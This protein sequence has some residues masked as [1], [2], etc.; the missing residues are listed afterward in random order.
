MIGAYR[1]L[2][3][4]R[5]PVVQKLCGSEFKRNGYGELAAAS[6]CAMRWLADPFRG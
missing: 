1:G 5:L 4:V 2:A 3:N 6:P